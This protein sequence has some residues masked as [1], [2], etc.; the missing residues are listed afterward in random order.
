MRICIHIKNTCTLQ[1]KRATRRTPAKARSWNRQEAGSS[2]T[3]LLVLTAPL[4]VLSLVLTS[5]LAATSSLSLRAGAQASLVTQQA[6]VRPCG[7]NPTLAAPLQPSSD[8]ALLAPARPLAPNK[9]AALVALSSVGPANTVLAEA[10]PLLQSASRLPT[11]LLTSPELLDT[12]WAIRSA[13]AQVAPYYFQ[14]Q[15]DAMVPG[16]DTL[17]A[18]ATFLCNEPDHGDQVRDQKREQLLTMGL[19]EATEIFP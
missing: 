1:L 14:R 15:A 2:A 8:P 3:E 19:I 10:L 6:A 13:S 12:N 11:E 17:S 9:Q 5:K 16:P 18:S 4:C 7:V